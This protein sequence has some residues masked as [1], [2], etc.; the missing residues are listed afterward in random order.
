MCDTVDNKTNAG[1]YDVQTRHAV[2]S[3]NC[4]TNRDPQTK[5]DADNLSEDKAHIP[6]YHNSS[7]TKT[8]ISDYF[9]PSTTQKLKKSKLNN[10]K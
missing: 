4:S 1:K 7:T 3:Q 10:H 5:L 6:N 9:I 2:D 8:Q